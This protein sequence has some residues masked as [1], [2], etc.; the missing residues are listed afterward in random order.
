MFVRSLFLVL[1]ALAAAAASAQSSPPVPSGAPPRVVAIDRVIAVVNDEAITQYELDD[2]RRVVVQQLKQQNVQQPAAD[3][4]DKQVLERLITERALLQHAKDSGI[5]VDDTQVE[6]AIQRIAED[7]KL[8]LDG[9]RQ[10]LA[11]EGVA[12]VRY[13]EDV[14]SEIVMQRLREREVDAR[15]TVSDAEVENYLA[16][17]K[18]QSGGEAEY[19]LAHILVLVPEQAN[20]EQIEA[21]RRRAEEAL[22]NIRGGTDFGQVAA[23][24]SDASDALSG[25]NL[26]WRP[27]ARLP[28]V[29]AETV[30]G[31]KA[32]DVSP[33][34]RSAAGFHIVKLIERR[35][36]NEPALV[37]QTHVRHILIRVNEITS[38][39]EGKA[40]IDRLK[41][42]LDGGAKFEDM[43]KLN[44][45][46]A[47]SAKGGDL[48][49]LG[50]GDTVPVFEETMSKLTVNQ[51]SA[52]VRTPFGWHLIEV[53][54]RRKQDVSADRERTQAQ[55]AIR[56]RKS[57][58]AFQDWVRQ[59]RDRA[60]VEVR[61][62][63]R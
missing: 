7:N 55:L 44:S 3:V 29:F 32:G 53:L 60:Y 41:D 59:T 49:W 48:G 42:R 26:G 22:K 4:L 57:D 35:S 18:A 15:I 33:V 34:L 47:S 20:A 9:L 30:R 8:T 54:G 23:G 16:T 37:D 14:R 39:A 12:Y 1:L 43:A 51:V 25:G 38:E 46:D 40:K 2:A 31:M 61:L 19:R 24:F 58:E 36:R 28:T 10:A 6:R 50:P 13:R 52:P 17:I 21:K 5:K 11:R 62:D 45:E 56:Q 63:D 27:G